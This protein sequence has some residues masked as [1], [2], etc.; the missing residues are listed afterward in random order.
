MNSKSITIAGLIGALLCIN[1]ARA[2]VAVYEPF[3]YTTS[4]P[5]GTASTGT[6]ESGNWTCGTTPSMVTGLTYTALP[7]TNNA[8]STGGGRMYVSLAD[9]ISSGTKWVSFL[10][11]CSG[12]SG[13]NYAGIYLK[14]DQ[15]TSLWAGFRGG[16]NGVLNV[17]GLAS[18]TTAGTGTTGGSPLGT[19]VNISNTAVHL[20]VIKIDFNTSGANDTVTLYLNPT[21]NT[22]S[23]S[24]AAT[25][26]LTTYNVGAIS[27]L[28]V[29][30]QGGT[31]MTVDEFRVGENFGD[32]VG[33]APP[34]PGI[35]TDLAATAGSNSVFLSWTAATGIPATYNVKRS[36]NSGSDYVTVGTTTVPTVAFT[37]AALGG[38]TYYYVV[39]AANG[40]G[41]SGDSAEA[42]AT[43]FLAAPAAPTALNGTPTN[44]SVNLTWTAALFADTF[45]VKRSTTSGS[46]YVTVG[47]TT[48]PVTAFTDSTAV[49][50]TV[51]YYVVSGV[52][53][54]GEGLDSSEKTITMPPAIATGLG[55]TPGNNSVDLNWTGA[56]G[57]TGY[58]VKRSTTSGSGYV[59][60]GTTATT[61]FTDSI[62][63]GVTYYYV[64]TATNLSGESLLSS[65]VPATP[66]LQAPAAPASLTAIPGNN[67]VALTWPAAAFA[68][69]Y[70]VKRSTISGAEVTITNVA[71]A[72]Y[73]DAT[74]V[75]GTVYYYVVSALNGAGESADTS[76]ST[77]T[78]RPATPTG[79]GATA[80]SNQVSL[81]WTGSSLAT[82]YRVKRSTVS[83]SGYVTI[84]TTADPITAF[85]DAIIGGVTYYYV[86]T[87]TNLS[88]ETVSSAE[89]FATPTLAPPSAPAGLAAAAG[90]NSVAL[91]WNAAAFSTSYNV[92]RSTTSGSGYA[93]IS[94]AGAVT[95]TNYTDSTAINGTPYYYVVSGTN[96]A[97]ES[98]N[99]S[100][101]SAT[102]NFVSVYEPFNYTTSLPSGTASTG[103][104]ESGNWTCGTTPAIVTGLTYTGLP[105]TNN[106]LS[107]GGGRQFVS[108]ATPTGS[109]TK[110][111]SFL[112][113]CSGDPGG[114]WAGVYLKGDH[115]TSLWAGFRGGVNGV[116]N[117]FGLATVTSAGTTTTGGTPQGTSVNI[118]NTAVHLIVMKIDFNASGTND[119]V[120]L[121]VNPAANTSSPS[122]AA[123]TS[124]TNLNIGTISAL[125]I[126]IQGGTTMTIDEFRMGQTF[127]EVVGYNPPATPTGLA[128][129]P[130][131]NTVSLNWDAV[132]TATG[133][134]V[135]RGTSTG[136]YTLTNSAPANAYV[137]NTAVG[138][139]QYFYVVQATNASGAS[140]SSLEVS[141][142]PTVALPDVPAG[143]TATGTNSAVQ[144]S[145]NVATGAA[146]YNVKR[147]TTSGT[148]V[149]ITNVAAT[150]Y[151]D[152]DVING[153]PYFYQVSSVNGAGESVNSSEVS[154]T[155]DLPPTAPTGLGAIAG[156]SQVALS[157]TG[158]AGAVSYN[159]KRSITSGS[160][161]SV[162]GTTT[163]PT[164][165][166]TDLS[167]I[168]FTPYYYVV[169]A[170]SAYGESS[171]SSEVTATPTG[172]YAA[173]AYESFDYVTLANGTPSTAL[174]FTGNWNVTG[175]PNILAGL[176]Y[177]D[178]PTTNSSYSHGAAG[179]Q[180]TVDFANPL[181]SG[182][183]YISF[184]LQGSGN[185]GGNACGIFLKGNN[186]NSLFV[187]FEGGFSPDL[188]SFG[189]GSVSSTTLG[190]ATALGSTTAISNTTVHLV[191]VA[192]EFNTSGNDDTVSLWIDPPAGTNAP[193][194]AAN[195]VHSSFDVGIISAFGI[196]I[197]GAFPIGI[198]EVRVGD[199]YGD[200]V[201]YSPNDVLAPP[202]LSSVIAGNQLTLSWPSEYL[203]W[204]LQSQTNSASVGLSTNWADVAGSETDT[205]SVIN[206]DNTQPAAYFRLR[207]P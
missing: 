84:G 123:T 141:A 205:N 50:G 178:L 36:T 160:G 179:A 15:A 185:P 3:N 154:A 97:G 155:P 129:T 102:P 116:L 157:W 98:V 25:T 57:A 14:G 71:T 19:S 90:D 166:F 47:S 65:E 101:V 87:A 122:V 39:S 109:G 85:N 202:S 70:N 42:S 118:A 34:I 121:Y 81:T 60:V 168:K 206:I 128:A 153:Q 198:D 190:G 68:T 44:N 143:L 59:T 161:Y 152:V 125:G 104:G 171:D 18:V 88:G 196:N 175:T 49:D 145:W 78:M 33:F 11:K 56:S 7:T 76:E 22:A 63:G 164:V 119:A 137:D 58:R 92:K 165:A 66:V 26:T 174:G 16:V 91:I 176:T 35:P 132:G 189:L 27:A 67:T 37:N 83:G 177:P 203:G 45:N 191:V 9:P 46:G 6:G 79:L 51:Y 43:P 188:T 29:N 31:T 124:I 106:A 136:V 173:S 204:F 61:V 149:T 8:L 120:T 139:T 146:S 94:T 194:L 144:L 64:V 200:V 199:V 5:N 169:S 30:I 23:P 21:A 40:T 114:N 140:A 103:T 72:N 180:T 41:E 193:A 138:G 24:V 150:S 158:S 111:V 100:E 181:S 156:D 107:T 126:N 1:S 184:L 183:K 55:A 73:S 74:A 80:G 113:K 95:G 151:Y 127:G 147:S 17:F 54:V 69:S 62:I 159:V 108:L 163:D 28:G 135:L 2:A 82:G 148:E 99:S 93:I 162:V 134:K 142:T 187:G 48:N 117:V 53:T 86:V 170:V 201:G 207:S 77:V 10:F 195:V 105:T 115:T 112:F 38:V 192:I 12:D 32:V 186:A 172:V 89:V 13:G 4:I 52:N 20:V 130:G 133:Y 167:A 182:T 110:W 96:A 75:N 197:N 131:V